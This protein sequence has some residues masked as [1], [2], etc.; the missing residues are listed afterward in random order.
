MSKSIFIV[1]VAMGSSL[2]ASS[3]AFAASFSNPNSPYMTNYMSEE[4]VLIQPINSPV[5]TI[6]KVKGKATFERRATIVPLDDGSQGQNGLMMCESTFCSK[7]E[8][9]WVLIVTQ[10]KV[11]YELEEMFNLGS[12]TPPESVLVSGSII[13]PGTRI[14]LEGRI[15]LVTP[16]YATIRDIRR[17]D[18]EMD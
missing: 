4:N 3:G 17:I 15:Q 7:S 9:Y 12:E 5:S 10:D 1:A 18:V 11:K 8:P 14:T 6:G 2:F 16:G 13:R